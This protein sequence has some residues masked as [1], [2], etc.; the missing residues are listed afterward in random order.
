[1]S[2]YLQKKTWQED[3]AGLITVLFAISDS[4][5]ELFEDGIYVDIFDFEDIGK[6]IQADVGGF[7]TAEL[8]LISMN[9]M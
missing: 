8:S 5:E 1:M 2:V 6:S 9:L 4:Y 3:G 7:V